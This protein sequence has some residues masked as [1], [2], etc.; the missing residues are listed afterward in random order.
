M[1]NNN[2]VVLQGMSAARK[3]ESAS[4]E[5]TVLS[6]SGMHCAGCANAVERK[7]KETPGVSDAVV[8]LSM[9]KAHVSF[10]GEPV[11]RE[12][13]VAAVRA[14]GYDVREQQTKTTLRI[15]GMHCAGCASN[16][17][18]FLRAVDGVIDA[19]VNL[20]TE[21]AFVTYD[22]AVATIDDL[23]QAV[24]N[25][26]YDVAEQSTEK[27]ESLV[28]EQLK[29][30]AHYKKLMTIGWA[31]T[32]PIMLVMLAHMVFN[33]HIPMMELLFLL[34]ATPV[35]FWVGADT[36]KSTFNVVR[37][38]G[39]NMD[40][41][42]TL[43]A[44]AAYFTGIAA[45]FTP[46]ASY[47][48]IAAMIICF[49][50]TG[51]YL[52]FKSK[53]RASQAIQ[54][55]LTLEARTARV[56]RHDEEVEVPIDEVAV[57]DVLLVKPGEKIPTDG[58]VIKGHS[59]VD[60][61][62]ATGE[63]LPVEKSEGDAVVG[64]TINKQGVL[65]VRAERIGKDTFFA[66]VI[67]LVEECQ[68]TKVPIQEFADRVTTIFVPAILLLA[69]A[70]FAGWL[71]FSDT[72]ASVASW[73]AGFIPWVNPTLGAT[74]LAIFAAVAV[75]VIACP[76][77]LGLATPTVLM[78]ASGMGAENGILIRNGAAI[79]ALQEIDTI[80]L[81][82]TGTMTKGRPEVTDVVAQNG[83]SEKELLGL[84]ASS[85]RNSEHPLAQALVT[86]AKKQG[87]V[88]AE[89]SDFKAI[90]GKGI[91]CS[92]GGKQVR[93]GSPRWFAELEIGGHS[94]Q[95]E[96]AGLESQG[97]TVMLIAV[98]GALA[99]MVALA[100]VLKDDS[101]Q[102]IAALK[103]MGLRPVMLSG[104]NQRTAKAVADMVGIDEVIAEVLPE[105][106][107]SEISRLQQL[108]KKVAMVGD[109]INDAAA[110][111]QAQVGIAIG[112]GTDIAI[113]ASD[114][115][116]V[117]GD[118]SSIVAAVRLSRATFKKIKQNLFWAFFY[119]VVMIPVAMLGLLHPALAEA[120]MAMSSINVVSNSLRL[121]KIDL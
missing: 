85:E 49:H 89:S 109:G 69:A 47:A 94:A 9:E 8:N 38:G 107:A 55:L 39:T 3:K 24:R 22:A 118:L 74:S 90:P 11:T 77:A 54:K 84:A 25:S 5:K 52:E 62:L 97:K 28:D 81:D 119:N 80:V 12:T 31:I 104:D 2:L 88:L 103:A 106:K 7:L 93:I 91:A 33:L 113:E 63:S 76:C 100:D 116:L 30:V 96:I 42:I 111:T 70:T 117:R 17:E 112:T 72:F 6:V 46:V 21:K 66:Q 110:L 57:G 40:V 35:V 41:L 120:A 20:A 61:S 82:K 23:K 59:A 60:E 18:K 56:L 95:S 48:A 87:S 71:I 78:V 108:G 4:E 43:G 36:H 16:V 13:L 45:F 79:Q 50:I 105:Q 34:A 26:G 102:A 98:D 67:R 27:P 92:V 44:F 75:L 53:G 101:K 58:T 1:Q 65:Q 115:T 99:G 14:A 83:F 51:R 19:N 64:A 29:R 86:H 32:G 73:A 10:S 15:T 37:H 68:G 121:R 114:I